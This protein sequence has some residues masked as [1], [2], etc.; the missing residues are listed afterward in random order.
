MKKK[1]PR[2]VVGGVGF[3]VRKKNPAVSTRTILISF[4]RPRFPTL[5]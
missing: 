3:L 4:P 2:L 5:L 1:A